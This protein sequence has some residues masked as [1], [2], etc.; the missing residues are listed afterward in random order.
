MTSPATTNPLL[1]FSGL[2][3]F[4]NIRAEHVA[5]ALE[6]LLAQA[7]EVVESIA[8]DVG[9]ASWQCVAEPLAE[10]LDRID[11]AWGA[12][13]HLNAVVSTPVL[14]DAY[15]A[16]L[17]KVTAFYADLAQHP[18]LY[19]RYKALAA[20]PA[21]ATLD[22]A[23]RR[24][25]DNELRDFRLG[26][27]DLPA[28]GKARLKAIQEELSD[29]AARFDDNLLDAT[30]EWAFYVASESDLAGVPPATLAEARAAA[31][32]DGREGYKLTLRMPCYPR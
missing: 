1:D 28:T 10:A 6:L 9:P 30:N 24:A 27:A 16:C 7:R 12:V 13:R 3:R 25:I 2:P 26:G 11:R 23:K 17:P 21:F 5:P 20:S 8:T 14:R 4:D 18:G 19:A 22:A 31:A 29:L 32:A 15:H